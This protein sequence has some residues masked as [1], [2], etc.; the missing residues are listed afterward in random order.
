MNCCEHERKVVMA[1]VAL[2]FLVL[3]YQ[4]VVVRCFV[5]VIVAIAPVVPVAEVMTVVTSSSAVAERP[6]VPVSTLIFA[7]SVVAALA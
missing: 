2:A 3:C 5:V 1:L 4:S 7:I 6:V